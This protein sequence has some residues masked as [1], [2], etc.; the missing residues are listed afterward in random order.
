MRV[1]GR[2]RLSRTN[3]SS[4]NP[5]HP[6]SQQQK[7]G[8]RTTR[9]MPGKHRSK[10]R[11]PQATFSLLSRV[12]DGSIDHFISPQ[13]ASHIEL[14]IPQPLRTSNNSNRVCIEANK[15]F[16][17]LAAASIIG[18]LLVLGVQSSELPYT[19]KRDWHPAKNIDA[20]ESRLPGAVVAI[21][22]WHTCDLTGSSLASL[23]QLP[24]HLPHPV[25][26]AYLHGVVRLA[27]CS[28]TACSGC[29]AWKNDATMRGAETDRLDG[30]VAICGGLD[31]SHHRNGMRQ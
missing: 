23:A 12:L 21:S 10:R 7:L 26:D 31:D 4:R 8:V 9:M 29:C 15:P 3:T 24:I 25:I 13:R 2:D 6:T 1:P 20:C 19:C 16:E 11:N 27:I 18:Y 14:Y 17:A 28:V 5:T 30:D 22:S